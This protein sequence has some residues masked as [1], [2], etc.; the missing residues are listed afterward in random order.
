MTDCPLSLSLRPRTQPGVQS[1]ESGV[2][3]LVPA[4]VRAGVGAVALASALVA[5]AAGQQGEG[6]PEAGL[7]PGPRSGSHIQTGG[8]HDRHDQRI[9]HIRTEG[10]TARVD[11]LRVGGQTRRITV[12]PRGGLPAY[13]VDA[14]ARD[15]RL[16]PQGER[17][18]TGP[19]SWR[20][21]EF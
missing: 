8:G 6:T 2:L 20:A 5:H 19:S 21:L 14:A 16:H 13:Q 17:A 11:E 4:L 9:E 3:A 7:A 10:M 15:H 1:V 18:T 12:Q